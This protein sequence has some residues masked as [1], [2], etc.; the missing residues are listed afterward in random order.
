[1]PQFKTIEEANE[2]LRIFESGGNE[3]LVNE[4]EEDRIA[5]I[6]YRLTH[7][8]PFSRLYHPKAERE[9]KRRSLEGVNHAHISGNPFQAIREGVC[10]RGVIK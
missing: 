10:F 4:T 5:I 8:G 7:D 1:M 9:A 2:I 6:A 3:D